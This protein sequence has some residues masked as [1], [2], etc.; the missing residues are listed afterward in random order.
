[1]MLEPVD[2]LGEVFEARVAGR[3]RRDAVRGLQRRGERAENVAK[4]AGVGGRQDE[5]H[6]GGCS[7]KGGE[8]AHGTDP[9]VPV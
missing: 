9:P 6:E 7:G 1:M 8:M 5:A 3:G 2:L 4:L